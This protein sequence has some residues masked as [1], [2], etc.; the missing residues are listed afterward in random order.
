[1]QTVTSLIG[2][3]AVAAGATFMLPQVVK[4]WKTKKVADLS[5]VSVVLYLANS[6]LWFTYG[7]LIAARPVIIANALA[8][9]ISIVQ[10]F[11]KFRYRASAAERAT[12]QPVALVS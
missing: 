2:Y 12:T 8:L 3:A 11:L 4:S 1:M 7:V 10:A 9:V 5:V 6:I